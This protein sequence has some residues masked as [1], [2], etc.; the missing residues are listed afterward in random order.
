[1]SS[2]PPRMA[3]VWCPDWPVSTVRAEHELDPDAPIA[4]LTANRVVACSHTARQQGIGRGLRRREAQGRCPELIVLPR[5]EAA[6]ARAFEPILAAIETIAPGVEV[7]RPGL[8]A[9]GIKGPTR[10]FGGETAVLHALSR[11]IAEHTADVLIGVADGAFAAEQAARRGSIIPAGTSPDF[12]ASLPVET[13]DEPEL[14]DLLKRLGLRTLGSFAAL[15]AADVQAR[16]GPAGAWAHRQAGGIDARPIAGR[17]PPIE[18]EVSISFE[19]PLDRVDTI[20]FSARGA[21]EE[22]V[23]ALAEHGLACTCFELIAQTDRGDETV[24][25]WRHAGV[26]SAVDV[27]D[28]IRWQLEGWLSRRSD[29][30]NAPRGPVTLLRLTPIETVPT[31]AHQR[32]LW[33]GDG[34]G[35][36]RAHRALARVQT[37][38]GHGSVATPVVSGG[39]GPAQR[40]RLIPW[41]D[42]RPGS[43]IA[44]QPWPGR[45][46][47]PAPSVILSP[48][49]P[50]EVLDDSGRTVVVTERGIIP[51]PPARV[52]PGEAVQPSRV[53]A[54][55]G[56]WPV[57]ERWWDPESHQ[58]LVRLQLVDATGR[59]YLV[60][61]DVAQYRWFLEGIYD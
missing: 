39:R 4:V 20:A 21:V 56:P 10:Y 13:I 9:I 46:P 34:A 42:D 18:F 41:G 5:N 50:V 11:S 54:W 27:T 57:D 45:L 23:S 38:L 49:R 29:A 28:R 55:A 14:V 22:F 47:S 60:C 2:T 26:L 19:P 17:R 30:V 8:A 58:Q 33:G 48:P 15:P 40:T 51:N 44:E 32:A 35:D 31:G 1:M 25:R 53:T 24:R 37:L 43:E 59:A 36:E 7:G 16:F 3:A 61:F 6:E 12:L 52:T